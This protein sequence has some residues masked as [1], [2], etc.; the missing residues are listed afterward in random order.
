MVGRLA[1]SPEGTA[2]PIYM[3]GVWLAGKFFPFSLLLV[4]WAM[5]TRP[6]R[7]LGDPAFVWLAILL[8]GFSLPGAKRV[9][10]VLPLLAP[11]AV[12]AATVATRRWSAVGIA[13]AGVAAAYTIAVAGGVVT[14]QPIVAA[15]WTR[16]TLAFVDDVRSETRGEGVTILVRSKHPL[17]SLLGEHG[18]A[19]PS[20]VEASWIIAPTAAVTAS[21]RVVSAPLPIDFETAVLP[22]AA[23]LGLYR[24][25][26]LSA[27]ELAAARERLRDWSHLAN[28]AGGVP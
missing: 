2:P 1:A 26:D 28:P 8:V 13:T 6:G 24:R 7:W 25:S 18:G 17:A 14:L 15:E 10:Y 12:L 5:T 22:P 9:D 19:D 4:A 21:P 27:S 16:A 3:I 20:A 23:P 11:A